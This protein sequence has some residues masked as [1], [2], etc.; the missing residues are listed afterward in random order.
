MELLNPEECY[1]EGKSKPTVDE[2]INSFCPA[3]TD[4]YKQLFED[5]KNFETIDFEKTMQKVEKRWGHP[6][7]SK[8]AAICRYKLSNNEV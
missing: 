7:Q 4:A 5:L 3:E 6:D 2:W 8:A 1:C